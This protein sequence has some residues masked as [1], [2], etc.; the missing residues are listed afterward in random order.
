MK[1]AKSKGKRNEKDTWTRHYRPKSFKATSGDPYTINANAEVDA[2]AI[3][4]TWL[5]TG[6]NNYE[7][8]VQLTNSALNI[9]HD[10]VKCTGLT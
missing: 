8:V 5:D 4:V 1:R 2:L 7:N 6:E 3:S 10:E 9:S